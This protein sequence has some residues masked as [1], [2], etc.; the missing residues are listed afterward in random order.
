[1]V[2][3]CLK[4]WPVPLARHALRP[5]A[6]AAAPARAQAGKQAEGGRETKGV[7][8]SQSV[9]HSVGRAVFVGEP[10]SGGGGG[11]AGQSGIVHASCSPP[12]S[13]AGQLEGLSI[14]SA[15]AL[16]LARSHSFKSTFSSY[17]TSPTV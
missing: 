2:D 3:E 13:R 11:G 5:A 6:D 8:V 10:C 17:E 1:M 9:S 14:S 15:S 4:S 16:S 12:L 7:P